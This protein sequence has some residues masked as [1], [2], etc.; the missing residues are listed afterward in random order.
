MLDDA[1]LMRSDPGFPP[2]SAANLLR[3][4]LV[5]SDVYSPRRTTFESLLQTNGVRHIGDVHLQAEIVRYYQETQSDVSDWLVLW[6][7]QYQKYTD[8]LTRHRVVSPS[9]MEEAL[10]GWHSMDV[11]LATSWE[12]V[13]HDTELMSRIW[14]VDA[15]GGNLLR[16]AVEAVE[17]NTNL[18]LRL[19][20]GQ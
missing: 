2:D 1:L 20:D 18:R 19:M 3:R 17:A 11:G 7:E 5:G 12:V 4:F 16:R 6:L 10:G 9:T 14:M 15:Y 13:R 8:H